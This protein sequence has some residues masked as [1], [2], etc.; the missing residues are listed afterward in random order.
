M[1]LRNDMDTVV[2]YG[3]V[4]SMHSGTNPKVMRKLGQMSSYV[5]KQQG[6]IRSMRGSTYSGMSRGGQSSV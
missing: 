4:E 2:R 1:S 3:G 6:A 5:R